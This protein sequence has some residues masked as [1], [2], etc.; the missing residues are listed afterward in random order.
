MEDPYYNSLQAKYAYCVSMPQGSGR[1]V[2]SLR[3][4]DMGSIPPDALGADFPSAGSTP[5]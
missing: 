3:S 4:I 2:G 1:T 5:R